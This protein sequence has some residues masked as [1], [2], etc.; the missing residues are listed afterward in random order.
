MT[1]L[2]FQLQPWNEANVSNFASNSD[3][4][5]GVVIQC[6]GSLRQ[7][8]V[9]T[10]KKFNLKSIFSLATALS[11]KNCVQ[12]YLHWSLSSLIRNVT[13]FCLGCPCITDTI[14]YFLLF[15]FSFRPKTLQIGVQTLSH[16]SSSSIYFN[17]NLGEEYDKM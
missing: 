5:S 2:W 1:L 13:R 9:N 6:E 4:P 7:C 10:Q 15:F 8:Q 3:N 17:T 11:M 12:V 14:C 16:K